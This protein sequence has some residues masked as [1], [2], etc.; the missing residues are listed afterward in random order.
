MKNNYLIKT[1]S[2]LNKQEKANEQVKNIFEQSDSKQSNLHLDSSR[3]VTY[4]NSLQEKQ[5]SEITNADK[6]LFKEPSNTFRNFSN[7]KQIIVK[8]IKI[9]D[10]KNSSAFEN[11]KLL[12][13]NN[14][15]FEINSN[16]IKNN[17]GTNVPFN[18]KNCGCYNN[19]I[20]FNCKNNYVFSENNNTSFAYSE[21]LN[22]IENKEIKQE[23]NTLNNLL[24]KNFCQDALNNKKT[25][26]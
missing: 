7:S 3:S 6:E 16:F 20:N 13:F 21:E 22:K 10:K 25:S 15:R 9:I 12:I 19:E 4:R 8:K 5:I 2:I 14:T 18:C 23:L 11:D 17:Y 26:N 1:Q 24:N